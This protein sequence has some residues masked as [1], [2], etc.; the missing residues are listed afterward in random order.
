MDGSVSAHTT[1]DTASAAP[2]L[3]TANQGQVVDDVGTLHPEVRFTAHSR[4]T[5]IFITASS[6]H[7]QFMQADYNS[8]TGKEDNGH[9]PALKGATPHPGA[10]RTHHFT[11]SL[12][13]AAVAPKIHTEE[14]ADYTESF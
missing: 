6:I 5:R 9:N 8:L 12:V 7:Y 2:L 10:I 4:S 1:A 3:F 11:L 13:G 14:V